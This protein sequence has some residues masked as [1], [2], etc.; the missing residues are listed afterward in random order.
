MLFVTFSPR[1]G[2][3]GSEKVSAHKFRRRATIAA[4]TLASS[5]A[6]SQNADQQAC[7]R[8]AIGTQ[9]TSPSELRSV[10]GSLSA[11]LSFRTSLDPTGQ[12]RY[13]YIDADGHWLRISIPLSPRASPRACTGT[14]PTFTATVSPRCSAELPERS[15]SNRRRPRLRKR[16]MTP[17]R[18]VKPGRVK[19]KSVKLPSVQTSP[20]KPSAL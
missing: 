1:Q 13:C 18:E 2:S 6:F 5:F 14:I 17:G 20:Y 3:A 15:S 12:I 8:P 9:L 4:F 10:H 19:R 11:A 16:N 7:P